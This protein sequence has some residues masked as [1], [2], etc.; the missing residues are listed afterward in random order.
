MR[1]RGSG[2]H[3]TIMKSA[4]RLFY[5]SLFA[6]WGPQVQCDQIPQDT[7][8]DA[9]AVCSWPLP[10]LVFRWPLGPGLPARGIEGVSFSG[11]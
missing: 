2:F 8:E 11:L 3:S 10:I 6:L 7:A 4:S 1:V 5:L 9:C